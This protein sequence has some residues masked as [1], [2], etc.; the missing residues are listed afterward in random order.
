MLE[1]QVGLQRLQE[2]RLERR[3]SLPEV[4]LDNIESQL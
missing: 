2:G 4:N 1:A 3:S